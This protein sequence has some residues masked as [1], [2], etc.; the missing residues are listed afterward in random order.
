M[1]G[2]Q[3]SQMADSTSSLQ[4]TPLPFLASSSPAGGGGGSSLA[5]TSNGVETATVHGPA[6]KLDA[7]HIVQ[8]G[9]QH[10]LDRKGDAATTTATTTG[11]GAAKGVSKIRQ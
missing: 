1:R 3:H 8:R 10:L 5:G 6:Q 7:C 11:T 9:G 4:A 2:W